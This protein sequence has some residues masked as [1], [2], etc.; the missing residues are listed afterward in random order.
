MKATSFVVAPKENFPISLFAKTINF[1]G[2][3][4]SPI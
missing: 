3:M 1:L 4:K 2:Q